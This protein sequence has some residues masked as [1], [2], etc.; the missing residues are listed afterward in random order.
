MIDNLIQAYRAQIYDYS[1]S[2]WLLIIKR[3][4]K[5]LTV[6]LLCIIGILSAVSCSL[7]FDLPFI[8]YITI[9]VE[10][11]LC[12]VADNYFVKQFRSTLVSEASHLE[13]VISFLQTVLPNNNLYSKSQ[14]EALIDRL[15]ERINSRQPLRSF[16]Q[17][18]LNF[19]KSIIVPIITYIAGIY[20]ASIQA[21]EFQVVVVYA[22]AI[23]IIFAIVYALYLFLSFVIRRITNRDYDA[24][25]A[26][27]EDLKD[28]KLL[29]FTA[30]EVT[31]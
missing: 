25:I 14:I 16:I 5:V 21:L 10:L 6:C 28:I 29:H 24:A 11:F 7:Y 15:S 27:R 4:W 9:I 22:L 19:G 23:I 18:L 26:L 12:M 31:N 8:M 2:D 3:K 13:E 1:L 20:S 17:Y 30:N